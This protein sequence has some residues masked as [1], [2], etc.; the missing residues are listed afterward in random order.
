MKRRLITALAVLVLAA[1]PPSAA[2]AIDE[3]DRLWLVGER[4]AA[5]G[6][7]TIAR[8]V[9]E[10]LVRDHPRDARLPQA[11]LILGRLR[12]GEEQFEAALDA[13]RRAQSGGLPPDRVVEARFWEAEALFHLRRFAEA[14]SAYEAVVSADAA[15]PFAPAAF[16]GLGWSQLEL[17][18]PE[19]AARA[20]R[21]LLTAW[22][23]HALA[24]SAGFY[25]GR[26]LVEARRFGEATAPLEH[27]LARHPTHKLAADA[28]YL[29]GLARINAGDPGGGVNDLRAFVDANPNHPEAAGARRLITETR[30]R[31]GDPEALLE[32]YRAL[33]VQSPTTPEALWDAATIAQRLSRPAEQEAAWRK[34]R[35]Q[36]PEHTLARRAALQLATRAFQRSDW[37]EA[38]SQAAAA[39]RSSEDGVRAEA[40]LLAG[41]AELKLRRFPDAERAFEAATEVRTADEGVRYRALAGLGLAREEQ[42]EWQR[43]LT[44]Y[45]EVAAQSS[46][47]TLRDWARERVA[48]VKERLKP[49]PPRPKPQATP[50]PRPGAKPAPRKAP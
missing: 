4:A 49:P 20:F 32:T 23:Q 2:L 48:A 33:M 42:R 17:K 14:R 9:L 50:Q 29:L 15:S 25:L 11:L 30:A 21:Q 1:L 36:F 45:E 24:P 31:Q 39:A 47:A 38:A 8:R 12:V 44:A 16:Y 41:E 26:A 27:F 5:D 43:A 10:R 28:R 22:P 40:W 7:N 46:D 35:E 6:L 37:K 3:A 18:Q 19:D 13:L 34:L